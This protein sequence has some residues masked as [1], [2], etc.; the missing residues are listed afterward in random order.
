MITIELH[1]ITWVLMIMLFIAF[2][3]WVGK[4]QKK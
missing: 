3:I 4:A 1:W 2:G